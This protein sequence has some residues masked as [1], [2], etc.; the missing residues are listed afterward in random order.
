MDYKKMERRIYVVTICGT[1]GIF[2]VISK[3][4]GDI[5]TVYDVRT[6]KVGYPHFLIYDNG[7]WKYM[8]AKHFEPISE[9]V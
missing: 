3:E 8:S 2:S 9:D 1:G 4:T 6:N 7:Q 5:K